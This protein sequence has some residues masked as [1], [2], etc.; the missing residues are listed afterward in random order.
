MDGPP[1]SAI[2]QRKVSLEEEEPVRK[3]LR[4]APLV[5]DGEKSSEKRGEE[6][7]QPPEDALGSPPPFEPAPELTKPKANP[8][9]SPAASRN[10]KLT[11]PSD[12]AMVKVLN[13]YRK[14]A[15][16]NPV[17]LDPVLSEGCGAHARYLVQNYRHPSTAGRGMHR[18]DPSLGGY[19]EKGALSGARSVIASH[20]GSA[21][22]LW[23]GGAV[24]GWM[25]TLYH[26]LPL[27]HPNLQK[28]GLG[29]AEA[30][31]FQY[32]V[33][34]LEA[35]SDLGTDARE[36]FSNVEPVIY[37]VNNQ[38]NVPCLFC[39]GVQ[40]YPNPI[41]DNGDSRAAGYPITVTFADYARVENVEVNIRGP[42][43]KESQAWVSTPSK[44]ALSFQ[45][46]PGTICAITK[47]PLR[48][49]TTYTVKVS[50]EVNGTPWTRTWRFT[51][52][53]R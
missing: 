29:Y 17:V 52:A 2:S 13:L 20:T 45:R 22:P 39:F 42:Q 46:Q 9:V 8:P 37:P 31:D 21:A 11:P 14:T 49:G 15:G 40:E 24:D 27:L 32:R 43:G 33:V 4:P 19:T 5:E 23:Q 35:F 12:A 50:A 6:T 25:A 18:E 53:L 30:R 1:P 47:G 28:I 48:P 3:P 26:R 44:P 10:D 16:L 7:R 51:T 34:V 36:F 38:K 41:P